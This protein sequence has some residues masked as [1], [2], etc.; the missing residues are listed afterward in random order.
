MLDKWHKKEKPVFTGITRGIGGFGFGKAAGGASSGTAWDSTQEASG[1]FTAVYEDGGSYYKT[2]TFY[3][4][5]AFVTEP[6]ASISAVDYIVVGAGGGG[7]GSNGHS[8][9]GGGGAG[10]GGV[11]G[12]TGFIHIFIL[13]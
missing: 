3:T 12:T 6:G 11:A 13:R 8:T 5:G 7:G 4:S 10:G 2:H 9:H 1:G